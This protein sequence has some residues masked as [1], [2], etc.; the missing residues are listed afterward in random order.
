MYKTKSMRITNSISALTTISQTNNAHSCAALA[1][2]TPTWL[3]TFSIRPLDSMPRTRRSLHNVL[4]FALGHVWTISPNT[5]A[6]FSYGFARQTNNGSAPSQEV[7]PTPYGFSSTYA[8]E[9]EIQSLPALAFTGLVSS[10][11]ASTASI[12]GHT[13]ANCSMQARCCSAAS[14]ILPLGTAAG[15]R[16]KTSSVS[17]VALLEASPSTHNSPVVLLRIHRFRRGRAR[18]MRGRPFSTD[19]LAQGSS[20]ASTQ[21][22]STNG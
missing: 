4:I 18:L 12:I 21:Y 16:R 8:S 11:G 1:R 22:P 2:Q 10:L 20:V 13:T 15:S 17:P 14:T 7:S 9:L 19:I 3:M 5:V 6:Q